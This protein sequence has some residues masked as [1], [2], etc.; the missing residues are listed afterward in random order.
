M[1]STVPDETPIQTL[2][3]TTSDALAT[4]LD[5]VPEEG[6]ATPSPCAGWSARDVV[7]HLIDTE[8]DFL[9]GH[10]A[11]LGA[12]PDL[13]AGPATAWRQHSMAVAEALADG[14]LPGT[15][16]DGHFGRTTVGDTLAQFYVFDL[17]V[18]RWD[19]ATAV[20]ADAS[21]TDAELDRI[22]AGADGFG[23]A[24]YLDGVCKPGVEAPAGAGRAT[25]ILAR[26]GRRG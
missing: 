15:A 25:R 21:L 4:V 1:T 8:R 24:L 20:G 9:T 23:D 22:E 3:D 18:H 2:Y 26:L 11:D 6:W 17:I 13:D 7:A 16:Y 19:I 5:A 14:S 10:G 12:A